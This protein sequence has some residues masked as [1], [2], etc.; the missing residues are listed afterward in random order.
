MTASSDLVIAVVDGWRKAAEAP[1]I[2]GL[3]GSQGSGKSTLSQAVADH[4]RSQG[5]KVAILSLDDLYLPPEKRPVAVHPLFATRGVPG[6]H[7]VVLGQQVIG[8]MID[9]QPVHLPRFD[10]ANDRP[11]DQSLWPLQGETPDILLFEGWCVGA[12]PQDEAD[13]IAP[14]NTLERDEDPD[15]VWRRYVN[16]QL[17]GP[18]AELF[19]RLDR[20]ILLAAPG[21][22][23]VQTWRSEQEQGLRKALAAEGRAGS[24]VMDE[25]AIT[26]FIA[27]YE[28]LTRHILSEMPARADLTLRLDEARHLVS[29]T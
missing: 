6:T 12:V 24:K 14:V 5:L 23:V 28:R 11:F 15:G 16:A 17:A 1:L 22:E 7:D 29:H 13:L 10:K 25:A 2:V 4:F 27:H 20:L 8:A 26:R 9:N 3:C 21:F 18:Y 19:A